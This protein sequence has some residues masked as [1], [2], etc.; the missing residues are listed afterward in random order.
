[1][2]I[3]RWAFVPLGENL[4]NPGKQRLGKTTSGIHDTTLY[5]PTEFQHVYAL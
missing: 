1:M 4:P 2:V 5:Q 3:D